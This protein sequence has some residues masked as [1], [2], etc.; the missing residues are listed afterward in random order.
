MG[1]AVNMGNISTTKFFDVIAMS[2][3]ERQ[4]NDAMM[5]LVGEPSQMKRASTFLPPNTGVFYV[6]FKDLSGQVF[7]AV[8]PDLVMS[9]AIATTFDCLELAQFLEQSGFAGRYR[10]TLD[11]IPKPEIICREVRHLHPM[12]DFDVLR[13]QPSRSPRL[14]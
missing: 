12:L 11:N 9:P 3:H 4:D 13:S 7:Q 2:R 1:R 10:V 14:N 6:D 5:L 8:N